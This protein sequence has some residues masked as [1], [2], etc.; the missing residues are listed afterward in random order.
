MRRRTFFQLLGGLATGATVG[1][2]RPA[3]VNFFA[4]PVRPDRYLRNL[5]AME[6]MRIVEEPSLRG[7]RSLEM[8]L[9]FSE[10][11]RTGELLWDMAPCRISRVRFS[12]FNPNPSGTAIILNLRFFDLDRRLWSLN[13]AVGQ[14]PLSRNWQTFDLSL[15]DESVVTKDR[16]RIPAAGLEGVFSQFFMSFSIPDDQRIPSR[17]V[18]LYL[19]GFESF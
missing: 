2:D 15:F 16:D 9:R 13:D 3:W 4:S 18:L 6:S 7:E 10:Q 5:R 19:D 1:A 8:T 11:Y 12:L 17:P 14:S